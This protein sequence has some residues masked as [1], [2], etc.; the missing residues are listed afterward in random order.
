[1]EITLQNIP[2]P[3]DQALVIRASTEGKSV[4]RVALEVLQS[5]LGIVEEIKQPVVKQD[6]D[7]NGASQPKKYRDLSDIAGTWVEDPEFD[8][9]LAEQRRIDP[10]LWK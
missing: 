2:L 7:G 1:M 3:L 4:D 8:A 9:I 10:E 5:S 6:T